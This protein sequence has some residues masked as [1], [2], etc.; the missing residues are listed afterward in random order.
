MGSLL[1][2]EEAQDM[3]GQ[4]LPLGVGQL[5]YLAGKRACGRINDAWIAIEEGIDRGR[6]GAGCSAEAKSPGNPPPQTRSNLAHQALKSA[7]PFGA[8]AGTG[9]GSCLGLGTTLGNTL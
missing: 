5:G 7:R 8:K 3:V 6:A 9:L 2:L 1:G 4:C